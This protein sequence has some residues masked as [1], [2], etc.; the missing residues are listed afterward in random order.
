MLYRRTACY[1][2]L[3]LLAL[4]L[5]F[6]GEAQ[7]QVMITSVSS[8][9]SSGQPLVIS[10]SGF[11]SKSPAAPLKWDDFEKGT[12]GEQL[13]GWSFTGSA[14]PQ[15]SSAVRRAN[16]QLSAVSLFLGST[17]LS[18]FGIT[19]TPLPRIYIDAWYY[20]DAVSPYSRNHKLFRIHTNA[21]EPNLYYNIYCDGLLS[22]LSQD[23]VSGTNWHKWIA[24]KASHFAKRWVH[25][26]GYFAESSGTAENG[27]AILWID[28][29]KY[30]SEIGNFQTRSSSSVYW[31]TI[32]FGNYLGHGTDP[33]CVTA[34]GD[35]RTYWDNVYVDVT[36]A[37]VE[38]GNAAT[39]ASSIVREIQ[40][41]ASW[42]SSSITVTVN[43]GA[44]S[45]LN[46]KYLY[47]TDAS[48]RVNEAGYPLCGNDCPNPPTNLRIE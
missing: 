44:W 35:A 34:Y 22:H 25:L 40:V 31:D 19:G 36:Q 41:P 33:L 29:V 43:S 37:R 3:L 18:S 2:Y 12:A 7:G 8:P 27:S 14:T 24:P 30:V 6:A 28:G 5:G 10:G 32:W 4:L 16:S 11:G 39:Y 45:S 47:V 48:G 1:P 20:Y 46:G 21:Y 17:Y 38:I 15:Y 42:S 26:Q 23:G 9:V 13:S